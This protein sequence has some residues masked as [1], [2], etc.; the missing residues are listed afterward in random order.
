[1][2]NNIL[3]F[4]TNEP[5]PEQGGMERVTDLLAKELKKSGKDV[6]L[7]YSVPNRLNKEYISPVPIYRLPKKYPQ[8]FFL[9]LIKKNNINLII[10]QTE[11]GVVGPYGYFKKRPTELAKV[12]LLAVQHSSRRA[13]LSNITQIY[14]KTG[15][16]IAGNLAAKIYNQTVL[17]IRN[18]HFLWVARVVHRNLDKNYDR[19]IVLSQ[20]L[21]KDFNHY[22]PKADTNKII[23]IPNPNTYEP[24][25]HSCMKKRVLFV[26][27]VKNNPKGVDKLLRIWSMVESEFPDWGLD[28]VGDGEDR[29]TLEEFAKELKL[30]NIVFH[31]FQNP[32]PFYLKASIICMTSLYEGFPMVLNEA[33]VHGVVP[34]VF[35]SFGSAGDIVVDGECGFLI[36][37]FDEKEFAN[38]LST[39]M[40]SEDTLSKM[41]RNAMSHSKM[42]S[43]DNIRN[44]WLKLFD[45]LSE[46]K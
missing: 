7:L 3:I 18:L 21:I 22:Y 23:A 29:A 5:L 28:I 43:R 36:K 41:S 31:G 16:G 10:D 13:V 19:T 8:K 6:I 24:D 35:N 12:F 1:M 39:L 46:K 40:N 33:M 37:P 17:R 9:D 30:R 14:G 2:I 34:I 32:E 45:S 11:G 42:F 15:K 4:N 25:Q 26:G 44:L 38:K 27:R 20:A